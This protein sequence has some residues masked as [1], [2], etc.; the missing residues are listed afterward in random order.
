M[1]TRSLI[2]V[3]SLISL[4]LYISLYGKS[5]DSP[6]NLLNNVVEKWSKVAQCENHN[7]ANIY[8][9]YAASHNWVVNIISKQHQRVQ[10]KHGRNFIK[11]LQIVGII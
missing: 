7:N 1:F 5:F 3:Y 6:V 11:C 4:L 9:S 2:V 10:Y 8:R